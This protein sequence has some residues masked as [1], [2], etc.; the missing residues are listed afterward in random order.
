[1][2]LP[3]PITLKEIFMKKVLNSYLFALTFLICGISIA[4]NSAVVDVALNPA[5]SFKAKT[6]EVKGEALLKGDTVT[7][8]N[9]IVNLKS[10]KTGIEVRDSHTLK[11]LEADKYTEAILVS[12][13]GKGGK[14][15]GVIKIKGI[16]KKIAGTYKVNGNQLDADFPLQ[17]SDFQI[18]GIRYMGVGVKDQVVLHVS[19]PLK[20]Q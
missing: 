2:Q 11:H 4:E 13:T 18:S 20:K 14:G 10:L 5:G 7:A 6:S 17:L 12:A 16:E 1:M 15:E 3:I 19:V 8:S 9:I